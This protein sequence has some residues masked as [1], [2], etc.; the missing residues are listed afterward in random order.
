MQVI[1]ALF[2]ISFVLMALYCIRMY[3]INSEPIKPPKT[4]IKRRKPELVDADGIVVDESELW[5]VFSLN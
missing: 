4:I 2:A 1:A 5:E 3:F